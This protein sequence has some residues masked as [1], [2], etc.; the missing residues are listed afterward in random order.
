MAFPVPDRDLD[1]LSLHHK[2]TYTTDS[3]NSLI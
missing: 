3:Y 2:H 1:P